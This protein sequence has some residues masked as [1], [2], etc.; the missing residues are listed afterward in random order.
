MSEVAS[1]KKFVLC[2]NFQKLRV[3]KQQ[4]DRLTDRFIEDNVAL[5]QRVDDA[6]LLLKSVLEQVHKYSILYRVAISLENRTTIG[7]IFSNT[8]DG[9]KRP[10][11]F[12]I[13]L[14]TQSS[15]LVFMARRAS[16]EADVR[17]SVMRL[18]EEDAIA[19]A[20]TMLFAKIAFSSN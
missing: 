1:P 8:G 9:T 6:T 13:A 15:G 7:L 19:D 17:L 12:T 11:L 3:W 10:Q 4:F 14:D 5:A 20:L 18:Q 2:Q 16:Y